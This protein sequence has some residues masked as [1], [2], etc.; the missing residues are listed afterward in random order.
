MGRKIA[1]LILSTLWHLWGEE[2]KLKMF[3]NVT[4]PLDNRTFFLG[5]LL[6]L[7][8]FKPELFLFFA[9]NLFFNFKFTC[10][11]PGAMFLCNRFKSNTAS[12][13]NCFLAFA[14]SG[15]SL[16]ESLPPHLRITVPGHILVFVERGAFSVLS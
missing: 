14:T 6:F 3:L 9:W 11:L 8:F 10:A 7:A 4:C 16:P 15:S 1:P 5:I 2:E 13:R 12:Q